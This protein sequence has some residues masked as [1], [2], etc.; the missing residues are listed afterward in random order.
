MIPALAV[1]ARNL[2]SAMVDNTEIIIR[3]AEM[4]D[5]KAIA[6]LHKK[7]VTEINSES[8]SPEAIEEWAKDIS[9]ENVLYQLQNSD[10]IIAEADDKLVGFG[11]YSVADGEIYQINVDPNFLKKKIGK[12]LYDY[13]ESKFRGAVRE[14]ISL[15]ATLNAVGFY[16]KL[17]F[18]EIQEIHMGLIKMIKMEKS[19]R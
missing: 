9:E 18:V 17:G 19:L 11:Q 3:K 10:W 15:N 5:A 4:D 14:K 2:K 12:K 1:A 8:Y 16:Q 6:E 7:V 13:M